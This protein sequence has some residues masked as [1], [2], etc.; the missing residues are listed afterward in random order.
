MDDNDVLKIPFPRGLVIDSPWR[1]EG[2]AERR[3]PLR[4]SFR[5]IYV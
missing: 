4:I 3:I 1:E 2:A 5:T